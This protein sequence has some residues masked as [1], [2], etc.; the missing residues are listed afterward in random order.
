MSYPRQ[1]KPGMRH[2][3]SR[4]CQNRQFFFRPDAATRHLFEYC[5]AEA[6]SK[7]GI[8]LHAYVLMSNHYHITLSDPRGTLPL[9]M[10]R[11]NRHLA[12]GCAKL[13]GHRGNIFGSG[14]YSDVV[15]DSDETLVSRTVYTLANP[16]TAG[17]VRFAHQWPGA[18]STAQQLL[19][20]SRSVARPSCFTDKMAETATLNIQPP[21]NLSSSAESFVE[22]VEV[23]IQEREQQAMHVH[24]KV[25]GLKG[26]KRTDWRACPTT[27][28]PAYKAKPHFA[29]TTKQERIEA[30]KQLLSFRKAYRDAWLLLK[31]GLRKV[32]FPFGTWWLH[33]QRIVHVVD[34]PS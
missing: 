8:V 5:L 22:S 33:Q 18:R 30:A 25:L 13:R 24:P 31:K 4:R 26:I 29:A 11:F 10:T 20:C 23:G 27:Q 28:E 14:S 17:L 7:H 34:A 2:M 1:I 32:S 6:A 16:V 9:M 21:S 12:L 3:V 19:G 15:L